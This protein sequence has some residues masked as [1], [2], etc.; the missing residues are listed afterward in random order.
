MS[1]KL[2][3]LSLGSNL[4]D[5]RQNLERALQRLEQQ[6]VHVT[7]RSAIYETEPQDVPGQAWFLNMAIECETHCFPLQLLS[8]L[9]SIEREMG[10]VRGAGTIRKGPR[11]IDIDIL[12]FSNTVMDNGQLTIPHPRILERRFMLEPLLEI[13]PHLK[14]AQTKQPLSSYLHNVAGQKMRRLRPE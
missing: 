3:Y 6:E 2:A 8:V 7:S 14:H 1:T 13:A 9:Q 12:L 11:I 4:G 10:R 5:R